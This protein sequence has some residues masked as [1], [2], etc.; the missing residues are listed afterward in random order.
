LYFYPRDFTRVCTRQACLFR[1]AEAELRELGVN[2]AGVSSDAEPAHRRFSEQYEIRFPLIA[3]PSRKIAKDYDVD[4]RLLGFAKRVTYLISPTRVIEGAFQ[5]ELSAQ[6]HLDDV[7]E[8]LR[9]R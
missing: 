2:I 1:D 6:K 3:D 8:M 7:R 5:H 9:K 4:R